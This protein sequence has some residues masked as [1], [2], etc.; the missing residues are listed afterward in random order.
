M[1]EVGVCVFV[2]ACKQPRDKKREDSTDGEV[3][4]KK[5]KK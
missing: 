1:F 4:A 2:G 5:K 3:K